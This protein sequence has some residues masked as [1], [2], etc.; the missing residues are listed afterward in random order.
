VTKAQALA[1]ANEEAQVPAP[2]QEVPTPPQPE[3]ELPYALED[4]P[5]VL[6]NLKKPNVPW[7]H[8]SPTQPGERLAVKK[9]LTMA[10]DVQQSIQKLESFLP[11]AED[12]NIAHVSLSGLIET[13]KR[14][15]D[16]ILEFEKEKL[17]MFERDL[18]E[19]V[20]FKIQHGHLDV[21]SKDS[22]A[23]RVVARW[24]MHYKEKEKVFRGDSQVKEENLTVLEEFGF[25]WESP[26]KR[27]YEWDDMLEILK[28]YKE[29]EG[30]CKVPQLYKDKDGY[31]LGNWV[32][33]Q[34]KEYEF[35]KCGRKTPMNP[36]R[37]QK[38][39]ELGFVWK[40]RHGR[41]KKNDPKFRNKR[42]GILGLGVGY[43]KSN[44]A[45]NDGTLAS[46]TGGDNN[47]TGETE[48]SN[49]TDSTGTDNDKT[50]ETGADNG[51]KNYSETLN[52]EWFER[53]DAQ[54]PKV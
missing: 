41:P 37:I 11:Q 19:L 30:H 46:N 48:E 2:P 5:S 13:Q 39:E 6:Q 38:L 7:G 53:A 17:T 20:K 28:A 40:L 21:V 36:D 47:K 16:A 34:R 44:G 15:R 31:A 24:R 32:S 29:R 9:S 8:Y 33:N 42:L 43:D 12:C 51:K 45:D 22:R 18:R 23:A 49:K 26:R 52:G 1:A 27:T 50:N 35:W 4:L 25:L 3:P 14:Q 10:Y 54:I